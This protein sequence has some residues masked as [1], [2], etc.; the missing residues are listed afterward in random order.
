M[1]RFELGILY[2]IPFF[3][4]CLVCGCV[5]R[6]Y[7]R[8]GTCISVPISIHIFIHFFSSFSN[9]FSS[10]FLPPRLFPSSSSF[11]PFSFPHTSTWISFH[12]HAC[13]SPHTRVLISTGWTTLCVLVI[14]CGCAQATSA[15]FLAPLLISLFP[16]VSLPASHCTMSANIPNTVYYHTYYIE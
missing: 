4:C 6:I 7:G 3:V 12:T 8:V 10:S 5:F 16:R 11:H 14:V 9:F 13:L 2:A 1:V 15:S